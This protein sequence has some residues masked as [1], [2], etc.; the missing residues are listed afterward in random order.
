MNIKITKST[1]LKVKPNDSDLRF[2]RDFTDHMFIMDYCKEKGWYDPKIVPYGPIPLDP[3]TC[4]LHYGQGIFEGMK[5]YN[6][7]NGKVLLFRPDK[8]IK[9][10]NSSCERLCIPTMNEEDVLEAIKTLVNLEK[11][12]IPKKEG[13]SLYIRPFVIATDPFLGVHPANTYMFMII[14]SPVGAYYATG[15]NPVKIYVEDKYVRAVE[16]GMG[17]VKT[18]GNYAASLYAQQEAEK[19]GCLQV[20][21][22]DGVERKYIEEVGAMNVFFKIDGKVIT[23]ML[24][25]SI[26]PGITRMSVI[27]LLKSKGITVEERKISIDEVIQAI[28]DNKLEECFG[29][30]TA[31]VI[32]PVGELMYKDKTYTIN[33]NKTGETSKM[34]YDTLTGIQFGNLDDE[35]NWSIEV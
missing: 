4:V 23:P 5:A 12:W 6:S 8:N 20:L 14:L 21:W 30:G 16:G 33:N 2:G 10:L 34:L 17:T 15:I 18:M 25:G 26:L 22:L 11:E 7:K 35:F 27:E 1:T 19:K 28:K 24:N 29:S 32:S 13:T 31:A 3:S 9:R